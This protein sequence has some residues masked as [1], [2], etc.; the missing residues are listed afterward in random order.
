M[1]NQLSEHR[2]V[3]Q[4][5]S[6]LPSLTAKEPIKTYILSVI[7]SNAFADLLW[8]LTSWAGSPDLVCT[9]YHQISVYR[10][11]LWNWKE[12]FIKGK[13]CWKYAFFT[14]YF[15]T[16]CVLHLWVRSLKLECVQR[17]WANFEICVLNSFRENFQCWKSTMD[18]RRKRS[19]TQTRI[20]LSHVSQ[21]YNCSSILDKDEMI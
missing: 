7:F 20:L 16:H 17:F 9:T 2:K 13:F 4:S 18:D 6:L 10:A 5:K 14:T 19:D 1:V 8:P 12:C 15:L 3:L 21:K 11:W